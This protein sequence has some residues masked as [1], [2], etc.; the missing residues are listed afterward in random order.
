MEMA[1]FLLNEKRTEIARSN[2]SNVNVL[3]RA[4]QDAGNAQLLAQAP[5]ATTTLVWTLIEASCKLAEDVREPTAVTP[6]AEPPT[7]DSIIKGRAA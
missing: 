3:M 7:T 4:Q 1:S 6:L 5:E 2:S